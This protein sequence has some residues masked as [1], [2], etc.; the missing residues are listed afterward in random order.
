MKVNDDALSEVER[1]QQ[2]LRH[3]IAE[4]NRLIGEAQQRVANSRAL[5]EV[6]SPEGEAVE[7][8]SHQEAPYPSI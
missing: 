5:T 8:P 3:N 2:S 1:G 7:Q 6:G 4:S